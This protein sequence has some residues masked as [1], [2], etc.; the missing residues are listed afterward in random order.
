MFRELLRNLPWF[1]FL[2]ELDPRWAARDLWDVRQ[3]AP[4]LRPDGS[5]SAAPE[6]SALPA[7]RWGSL[8]D[9]LWCRRTRSL[10]SPAP[11]Q[12]SICGGK[13]A[14]SRRVLRSRLTLPVATR[15]LQ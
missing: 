7:R 15:T 10:Y 12:A 5:A 2:Y 13:A 4:A 8:E 11:L 1:L 3:Y 6:E 14:G 9:G